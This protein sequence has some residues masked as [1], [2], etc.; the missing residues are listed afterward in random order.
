[1]ERKTKTAKQLERHLKGIANHHRINI[2]RLIARE[3]GMGVEDIADSLGCNIKT[4]SEHIKKLTLAGLVDK[5]YQGR[6]VLHALS[7]YG[8]IFNKFIDTF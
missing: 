5:K 2:L 8:K 6:K 3:D 1:M 7:P 4:I